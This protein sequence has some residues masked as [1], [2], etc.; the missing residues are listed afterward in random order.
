M[1]R[2][3]DLFD[4]R[5]SLAGEWLEGF[6]RPWEALAPL[7]EMLLSLGRTLGADYL[8][9]EPEVWVHKTAWISPTASVTGPCI[10]GPGTQVRHG[11]YIRGAV[12]T[13]ENCLVGNSVELKNVILFDEVQVPHFNYAGDSILGWKAHMGA[14]SILSNL[15]ADKCSVRV[16]LAGETVDTG[17]RKLGV[18]AG[19]RVEIGCN[20]VLNPGTVA[21][22]DSIIQPNAC[23]RGFV[24]EGSIWKTGGTVVRRHG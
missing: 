15:R 3:N 17:L 14:G 16:V 6:E 2:M 20:S 19:D 18:L 5:H 13:G 12:L 8:R 4:L 24:P 9:W 10:L 22:R 23:V 11:A 1:I 21:G 7:G